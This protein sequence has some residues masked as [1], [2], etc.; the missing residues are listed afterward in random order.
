M[1][2]IWFHS[3]DQVGYLSIRKV[4]NSWKGEE[5]DSLFLAHTWSKSTIVAI[6]LLS[7]YLAIL[8]VFAQGAIARKINNRWLGIA[9]CS[10]TQMLITLSSLSFVEIVFFQ[11][12]KHKVFAATCL[13]LVSGIIAAWRGRH[14][15]SLKTIPDLILAGVI[16]LVSMHRWK[17]DV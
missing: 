3:V 8:L 4:L 7:F 9:L 12:S 10:M 6:F 2:S 16:Y 5:M 14:S 15:A 13:V 11:Y 1:D 17:W